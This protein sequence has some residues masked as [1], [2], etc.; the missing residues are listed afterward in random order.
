MNSLLQ[1]IIRSGV[2][3]IRFWMALTGMGVAVLLIL[4]AVQVNADFNELLH[5][6]SNQNESA[7]FLVINK[8]V[9]PENQLQKDRNSFS[10][11]DI[12]DLGS[13]PFV[14][15]LG[16]LSTTSFRVSVESYSDALPF[17]SDAY[18]ESVPDEFID[19]KNAEWKWAEGQRDVPVIIPSFFLDLYNT[20]MAMSQKNLPQLSLQAIQAIPV[21]VVVNGNGKRAEFV[22]HVTGQSDRINSILIPQSFMDWANKEYGYSQ[23]AN[24][25]RV[26]VKVKDPTD[27]V[28]VN[29]LDK[30]GWKTNAEKTRFSRMRKVVNAVVAVTGGIGLVLLLFGLLVFSLFIQLTI[31]SCKTDIELLQTLGTSP[32]QLQRFLIKQFL[33]QNIVIIA[34]ACLFIAGL[35]WIISTFLLPQQIFI[36]K[37]IAA[38]TLIAAAFVSV[39]I[40]LVNRQ[41]ISKY[42]K[43]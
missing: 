21:K 39:V 15:S 20:G 33:P 30:K 2:G 26:V 28:L 19:A 32:G 17:Y 14:E 9:T 11:A 38:D 36:S 42:I 13:Q 8:I 43:K 22:G 29:Y 27:P 10:A 3:K 12:T 18:F 40:W 31:A 23:S 16:K 1:K 24:P 6:K 41:T 37:W 5:G 4:L 35:Q 34:I 7:D 25:T